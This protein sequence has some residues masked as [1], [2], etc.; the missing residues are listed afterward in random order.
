MANIEIWQPRWKD[1]VVLIARHKVGADN[2]ITFTKTKSLP[3]TYYI[4]GDEV[5]ACPISTNGKIACYAVPLDD[6]TLKE[7]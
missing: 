4:S 1:R 6:L 7:E 5:R 2:Y 3:G